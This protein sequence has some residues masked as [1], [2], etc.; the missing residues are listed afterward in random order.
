MPIPFNPDYARIRKS[1]SLKKDSSSFAP[2]LRDPSSHDGKK[3]K[4]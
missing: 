1:H 3:A 2:Q 4:D